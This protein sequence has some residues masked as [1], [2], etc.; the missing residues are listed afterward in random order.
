MVS[1]RA[2]EVGESRTSTRTEVSEWTSTSCKKPDYGLAI[3][4]VVV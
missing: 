1:K 2:V 4:R 3:L